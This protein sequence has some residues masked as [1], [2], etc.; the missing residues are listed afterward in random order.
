MRTK[1][2]QDL[3]NLL[4][5]Q[6]TIGNKWILKA[7]HN[8]NG[9]IEMY[10]AHLVIKCY[11]QQEDINYE[12][13]FSLVITFASVPLI[14]AIVTYIDLELYQIDIKTIFLNGELN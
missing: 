5:E 3:V 14:L 6:K 10:K 9:L 1:Q 7:K 4:L 11:T 2:V 13:A 12:E 8:S